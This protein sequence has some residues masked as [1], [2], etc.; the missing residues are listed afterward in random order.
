MPH[1]AHN[2][3][4]DSIFRFA[5]TFGW[6]PEQICAGVGLD[7]DQALAVDA[8]VPHGKIIDVM[9]WCGDRCP[10][11]HFGLQLA[12]RTDPKTLG[13]PFLIIERSLSVGHH[14]ELFGQSLPLHTTGYSYAFFADAAGAAGRLLI[15]SQHELAAQHFVECALALQVRIFQRMIHKNWRPAGVEFTHARMG[16]WA[17]YQDVFGSSV[18]FEAPRNALRFSPQDLAWRAHRPRHQPFP[19]IERHLQRVALAEAD[20]LTG[21]V[22]EVIRA[23]LPTKPSLNRIA[24][25]MALSPR[26]LQRRLEDNGAN[27]SDLLSATRVELAREYLGRPG[28]AIAEVARRLGFAH[29]G[30]LSRMLRRELGEAPHSLLANRPG[31]EPPARRPRGRA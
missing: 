26:T 24:A 23:I 20:D 3:A 14:Y 10:Q 19:P 18:V 1:W 9:E 29:V 17:A 27:F 8:L 5:S 31:L 22:A 11:P 15:H 4:L 6:S 16:D 25:E 28:A 7:L 30:A 12:A 2:N 13:L 21:R